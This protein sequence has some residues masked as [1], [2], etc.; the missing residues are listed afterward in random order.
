MAEEL[1]F[2]QMSIYD[3]INFVDKQATRIKL[4]HG[5]TSFFAMFLKVPTEEMGISMKTWVDWFVH[6]AKTIDNTKIIEVDE[7]M[8]NFIKSDAFQQ[9]LHETE[10]LA[11]LTDEL[12]Q[13]MRNNNKRNIDNTSTIPEVNVNEL[14]EDVNQGE[15]K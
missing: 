2:N 3:L 11:T 6:A 4:E 5:I 8:L 13:M 14:K 9:I 15:D 10:P 1:N 12:N 7:K